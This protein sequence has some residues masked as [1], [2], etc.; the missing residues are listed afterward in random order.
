MT[1]STFPDIDYLDE[2]ETISV[3]GRNTVRRFGKEYVFG[4]QVGIACT[5]LRFWC[6]IPSDNGGCYEGEEKVLSYHQG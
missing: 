1:S 5:T 6:P 2:S 3:S 4:G